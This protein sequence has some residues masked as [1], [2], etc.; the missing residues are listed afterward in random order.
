MMNWTMKNKQN[1]VVKIRND[2]GLLWDKYVEWEGPSVVG[3]RCHGMICNMK[4][5]KSAD[6]IVFEPQDKTNA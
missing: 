2:E 5:E 4:P 6:P 3:T 1:R